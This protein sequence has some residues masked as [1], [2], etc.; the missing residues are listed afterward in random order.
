MPC[1]ASG[2][3]AAPCLDEGLTS[4]YHRIEYSLARKISLVHTLTQVQRSS[5][6]ADRRARE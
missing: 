3:G 1:L 6:V 5:A 2:T 4:N